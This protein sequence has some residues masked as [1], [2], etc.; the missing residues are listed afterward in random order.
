M[1]ILFLLETVQ[2]H[3]KEGKAVPL[4]ARCGPEGSRNLRFSGFLTTAQDSGKFVS[5]SHRP[6]LSPG[7]IPGTHLEA[8]ST[9]GP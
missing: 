5:L 3:S 4:Q 8:E 2:G 9:P 1:R 6:H 7:N